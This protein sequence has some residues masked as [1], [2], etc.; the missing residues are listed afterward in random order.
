LSQPGFYG[1]KVFVLN[2]Q[3]FN[4]TGN[5]V[6]GA[7]ARREYQETKGGKP[8]PKLGVR[9]RAQRCNSSNQLDPPLSINAAVHNKFNVQRHLISV[10]TLRTLREKSNAQWQDA[11]AAA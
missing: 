4:G 7:E 8:A 11:V 9:R 5:C 1:L 10:A 2:A 3:I 6:S